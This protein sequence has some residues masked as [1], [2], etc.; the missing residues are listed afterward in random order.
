VGITVTKFNAKKVAVAGII[1]QSS[2]VRILTNKYT[3]IRVIVTAII[4]QSRIRRP[5]N[6]DTV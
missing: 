4:P 2:I 5:E 6:I 3:T 1:I